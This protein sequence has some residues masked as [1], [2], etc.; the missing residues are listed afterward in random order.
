MAENDVRTQL[1]SLSAAERLALAKRLITVRPPTA[2]ATAEKIPVADRSG[3]L[4]LAWPMR[5]VLAAERSAPGT[6]AWLE[7]R[8]IRY[9]GVDVDRL[10]DAYRA[11]VARHEM[12]RTRIEVSPNGDC[13]RVQPPSAV[14]VETVDVRALPS[15]TRM[16]RALELVREHA[17]RPLGIERDMPFDLSVCR[18]A[19]DEAILVLRAH[20]IICD[21]LAFTVLLNDVRKTYASEDTLPPLEVQ[22][23]DF[24]VWEHERYAPEK[25][26]AK[27]RYWRERLVSAVPLALPRDAPPGASRRAHAI[28][29][30]FKVETIERLDGFTRTWAVT[31]YV[32]LLA[33][34]NVLLSRIC[35]TDDVVTFATT[36]THRYRQPELLRVV[37]RFMNQIPIRVDVSGDPTFAELVER[38]GATVNDGLAN[39]DVPAMAVFDS[40]S[41]VDGPFCRVL[42]NYADMRG[43]GIVT[44]LHA[45]GVPLPIDRDRK[46]ALAWVF[47]RTE[48]R[49]IAHL[50][51][52][53]DWFQVSTLERFA[54]QL[55][56][57]VDLALEDPKR[58]ISQLHP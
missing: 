48:E 24:A 21:G 50:V 55:P 36:A 10:V 18:V 27:V 11:I 47:F 25:I 39:E 12:L 3:P 4:P 17:L 7:P 13:M 30:P 52:G 43:T 34:F 53:E 6:T 57:I 37:G 14:S 26:E 56:R 46:T 42:L 38:C 28:T 22:Y 8:A 49:V 1:A 5:V 54:S 20:E 19:D 15:E 31:H 51:G 29:T 2:T 32:I 41:P 45:S 35:E 58:R 16:A 23:G 33:A 44:R 40:E 9:S